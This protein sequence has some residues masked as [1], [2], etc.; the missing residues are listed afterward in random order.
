MTVGGRMRALTIAGLVCLGLAGSILHIGLHFPYDQGLL[1]T[2]LIPIVSLLLSVLVV[3]LL[4]GLR[5]SAWAQLLN[6]MTSI[7]GIVSMSHFWLAT[8]RNTLADSLILITKWALGQLLFEAE[9]DFRA[10][11]AWNAQARRPKWWRFL[12]PVW[13]LIHLVAIAAVY[14]LGVIVLGGEG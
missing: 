1:Y 7:V 11:R 6:G 14:A 5:R 8:G 13:W 4:F 10:G 12:R 9:L 3:P 2:Y